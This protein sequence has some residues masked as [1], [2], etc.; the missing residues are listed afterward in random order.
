MRG[1]RITSREGGH[2]TW[3]GKI[4]AKR[5]SGGPAK[6]KKQARTYFS[7]VTKVIVNAIVKKK[8]AEKK[9][10]GVQTPSDPAPVSDKKSTLGEKKVQ[11]SVR[12]GPFKVMLN[13]AGA[14]RG[15]GGWRR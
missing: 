5:R 15:G 9:K 7:K 13:S 2:F 14:T 1:E 6:K 4:S 10:L 3:K 8:I 11:A 12:A